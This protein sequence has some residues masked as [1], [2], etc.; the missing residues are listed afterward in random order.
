MSA[1]S[2]LLVTIAALASAAASAGAQDE[3]LAF[4]LG[5]LDTRTAALM[6]S[7]QEAGDL[8]VSALAIPLPD[9]AGG[10]GSRMTLVVDV[11]GASLLEAVPAGTHELITEIYAYA[12]DAEGALAANLTRA[13]SL[14][15]ERRRTRLAGGG[16][17]FFGTLELPPGD[18]SLRVLVSQRGSGRLGLRILSA[19]APAWGSEPVLLP[20]VRREPAGGW[21]LVR[22]EGQPPVF[23]VTVGGRAWVPS[24]GTDLTTGNR[25]GY[26]LLGRGMDRG[27]RAHL[28]ATGGEELSELGLGDLRSATGGPPGI[29][30][31]AAELDAADLYAGEYRL[32][33]AAAGS[34]ATVPLILRPPGGELPPAAGQPSGLT[35]RESRG[36]DAQLERL[37][38]LREAYRLTYD[39]LASGGRDRALEPLIEVHRARI[40]SGST[41]EQKRLA[42]AELQ[43][44]WELASPDPER[45]LAAMRVHEALYRRYLRD[46][47]FLLAAHSRQLI[48]AVASFYSERSRNPEA[49]HLVACAIVSL[50]GYLHQ[51]GSRPAANDAYLQAL[52]YDPL[53]PA[54]L[55]GLASIQEFYGGY[56]RAAVLLQRLYEQ[57]PADTQ[58]RLRLG[59]NLKRQGKPKRAIPHLEAAR[60]EPG[61]E[62]V[63]AVAAQEL[64]SLLAEEK[65]LDEAIGVLDE[66][67]AA[68]P[69]VQRLR[70]QLAALLDHAGRPADALAVLDSLDPTA[71]IDVSSPR[72]IYTRPPTAAIAAARQTL[73]DVADR[74]LAV[75]K[76]ARPAQPAAVPGGG[77]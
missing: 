14:D 26:L 7:D 48:G 75:R 45:L 5:G 21:I 39:R 28:L 49:P 54:A 29:E 52:D 35:A 64:A 46:R 33:V 50:A 2:R 10:T 9:P 42:R 30:I 24:T 71:G 66:A 20:P 32:R 47:L 57:S 11:G 77:S 16:V 3:V 18:Y 62:W 27:L 55:I 69:G 8:A 41:A 58:V 68:H 44:A 53:H 59:I 74:Q 56:D 1:P 17:K 19:T 37:E 13:F 40:G 72:L 70:V 36:R 31:L 15:L 23:P 43:V 63:A 73:A 6:L 38:Q 60:S 61:P 12:V 22:A 4:D 51:I 67:S 76:A 25:A 34:V 65:R